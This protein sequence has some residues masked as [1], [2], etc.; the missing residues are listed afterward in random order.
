MYYN[1]AKRG[2]IVRYHEDER[3]ILLILKDKNENF[4]FEA[5]IVGT[6]EIVS[7]CDRI[8]ELVLI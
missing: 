3:K 4:E 2:A 7:I 5:L 6:N 1:N 8:K